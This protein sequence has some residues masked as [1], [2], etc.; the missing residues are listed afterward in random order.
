MSGRSPIGFVLVERKAQQESKSSTE[1]VY[2]SCKYNT[3][4]Q[5]RKEWMETICSSH[6]PPYRDLPLY[7]VH[8]TG[9]ATTS[10]PTFLE[11]GR[12]MNPIL[13]RGNTVLLLLL[14]LLRHAQGTPPEF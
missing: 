8:Q 7:E 1:P 13:E 3:S 9:R 11:K 12:L 5:P 14:L 2:I 4:V 10:E 6:F